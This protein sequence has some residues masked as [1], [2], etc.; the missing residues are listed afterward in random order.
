MSEKSRSRG[1]GISD[2]EVLESAR[3]SQQYGIKSYLDVGEDIEPSPLSD[4]GMT[5]VVKLRNKGMTIQDL[6]DK[7]GFKREEV[8]DIR[9]G[10]LPQ[11][12][13]L[14]KIGKL[15]EALGYKK[16]ELLDE[17]NDSVGH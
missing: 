12:Q 6:A 14:P 9:F 5:I 2:F 8:I 3:R 17:F 10:A 15:E 11:N 1:L 4:F 7:T 16:G 13:V